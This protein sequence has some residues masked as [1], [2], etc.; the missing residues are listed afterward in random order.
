MILIYFLK[1]KYKCRY[2]AFGDGYGSMAISDS[3][4][5]QCFIY[6]KFAHSNCLDLFLIF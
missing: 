3:E 1:Y 4:T 5:G 6:I 2:V